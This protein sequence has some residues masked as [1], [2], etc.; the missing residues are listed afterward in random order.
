VPGQA[1]IK[2]V[3]PKQEGTN[4]NTVSVKLAGAHCT[5]NLSN[6]NLGSI[7]TYKCNP[8]HKW[9]NIISFYIK[10]RQT[11]DFLNSILNEKKVESNLNKNSSLIL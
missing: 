2:K 9:R 10:Y 11:H 5:L 6:F 7:L 3:A 8:E 1:V 4:R